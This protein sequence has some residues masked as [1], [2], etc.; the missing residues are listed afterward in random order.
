MFYDRTKFGKILD[1]VL[2]QFWGLE[3][4]RISLGHLGVSTLQ[5]FGQQVRYY[6]RLLLRLMVLMTWCM[7][8]VI[9]VASAHVG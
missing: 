5:L 7:G 3:C 9:R 8:S 2:Y 6:T 4:A 1:K